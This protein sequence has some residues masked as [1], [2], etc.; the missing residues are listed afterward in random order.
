MQPGPG[1]VSLYCYPVK[2]LTP[3]PLERVTLTEGE[4]LPFDRA[5]AIEAGGG[6]FDPENPR[7]LPKNTFLMLMRDERL[8]LLRSRFDPETGFLTILRDGK[9]VARGNL[10]ERIGR[11]MLEQ[12]FAAFMADELRGA[13]RIVHAEGHS[14][15]D[16]AAKAVSIIN[17]ASVR[18]LERVIGGP[19]DPLRFRANVYVEGLEAWAEFDWVDREIAIGG[20]ARLAVF[21]RIQRCAATNVA[22]ATGQRD[23]K[24]PRTLMD[25]FGHCDC[26]VYARVVAGGEIA[27]G[28]ALKPG[29]D[30][31]T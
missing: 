15:S 4:T 24:I 17:L 16:V 9:Q 31:K 26:G 8:A 28:Q 7:H 22:P 14:F 1:I 23:M 18:E 12:F 3:E 27:V 29:G 5:F 2:G 30:D 10:G 25:A 21:T 19:V 13:P 11:Q 6:E 20:D